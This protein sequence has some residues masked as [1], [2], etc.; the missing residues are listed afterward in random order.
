MTAMLTAVSAI[1]GVQKRTGKNK[2][3]KVEMC[4]I[5]WE[6]LREAETLAKSGG[7]L[8]SVIE[9]LSISLSR[10]LARAYH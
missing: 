8:L 5:V 3:S 2:Y 1:I 4:R 10:C 9:S 7:L 6:A